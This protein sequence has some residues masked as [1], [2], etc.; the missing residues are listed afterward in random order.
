MFDFTETI[1]IQARPSAVWSVM[2]DLE[3]WWVA[4][5]PEHQSLQRLDDRGIEV[6]ARLRIRE[7]VAGV[8]GEYVGELT[9]VV[10]LSEV[11]MEAPNAYYRLL[12]VRFTVAEG[13]TWRLEP[14][15]REATRVSARVWATFPGGLV[16]RA[17]EWVFTRLLN[18]IT[19]DRAHARLE[20]RHLRHIIE[21]PAEPPRR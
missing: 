4:S 9:R 21:Q 2:T 6:G 8:P 7:K 16:G 1:L 18:G 17:A 3:N 20:L 13:V 14:A 10:P 19:K 15:G 5:N 11:T 12:G